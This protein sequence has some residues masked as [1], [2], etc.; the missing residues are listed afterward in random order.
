MP[1]QRAYI[2]LLHHILPSFI[3][4]SFELVRVETNLLPIPRRICGRKPARLNSH[5][6]SRTLTNGDTKASPLT[7]KLTEEKTYNSNYQE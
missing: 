3:L 7:M 2:S 1:G 6:I 4:D 5:Y